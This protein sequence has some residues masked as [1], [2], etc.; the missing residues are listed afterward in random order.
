MRKFLNLFLLLIVFG[1]ATLWV[2]SAYAVSDPFSVPNNKFGIHL[3]SPTP[4]ESLPAFQLVNS[5]GGDWGYVTILIESKDLT[6]RAKWQTFFDDLRKKHLIPIVRLATRPSGQNWVVPD[7]S[8]APQWAEFLGSLNWPTK[9]RYVIVYNEPNHGKEWGGSVDATSYAKVLDQTITSL[10]QKSDDFFIINAGFDASTPNQPPDYYDEE[11]FV[12]E[13]NQAV[14]GILERLDGWSSHSYP[15]P[16]FLGLPTDSGRGTIRT[17]LW[18]KQMLQRLGVSKSLPIFIT[19]TGWQHAEGLAYNK[20]L[21]TAETVASYM[22]QA[23]NDAWTDSSIVAVTPFLLDYQQAPFDHFSFKKLT[24]DGQSQRILGAEYPPYYPH[25]KVMLDLQK[26]KGSPQQENRAELVKGEV[27]SSLVAAQSYDMPVELKNN[28]QSIWDSSVKLV[29]LEGKELGIEEVPVTGN[30]DPGQSFTF[31]LKLK[32]PPSGN[33]S[34]SMNLF[35]G[36]KEFDSP[37]FQFSTE[38]R[39]PVVLVVKSGLQWKDNFSGDYFLKVAGVVGESVHQIM[40]G[41]NG[42]SEELEA[43]YLLPDYDF[44][45]TLDKPYYKPTTVSQKV[46]SGVNI[47]DFGVLQPDLGSAVL[48]PP[49][50]WQLL[51]FSN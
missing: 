1:A 34:V 35:S 8:L 48:N 24:G 28:G 32:S 7:E 5:S 2:P 43:L 12:S 16:G 3:I 21:P 14:P 15:N 39:S 49:Q 17:Y 38:V 31:N 10:K 50:F 33:F 9:N 40:V 47:I 11:K 18:E 41:D 4:D 45:F 20:S 30:V 37:P 44:N 23:F 51:P 25:Y 46:H 22:Q 26:T 13:M 29:V 6:E 36:V 27:Y 19:E 42:Q